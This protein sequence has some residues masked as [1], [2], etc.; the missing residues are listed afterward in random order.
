MTI[1]AEKSEDIQKNPNFFKLSKHLADLI[2]KGCKVFLDFWQNALIAN[3][4]LK[5][6][7][8]EKNFSIHQNCVSIID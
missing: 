3:G 5:K 4:F 6:M 8:K 7:I 1:T 2:K